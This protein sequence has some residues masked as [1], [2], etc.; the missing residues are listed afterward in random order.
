MIEF[1]RLP[2]LLAPGGT[3]AKEIRR[4]RKIG[5]SNTIRAHELGGFGHRIEVN[6]T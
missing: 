2:V 1:W 4:P 3:P 6:L 5:N